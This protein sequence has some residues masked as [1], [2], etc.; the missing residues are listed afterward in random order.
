MEGYK[1]RTESNKLELDGA[2]GRRLPE[3]KSH[4]FD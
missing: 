4:L 1:P 2:A 3:K